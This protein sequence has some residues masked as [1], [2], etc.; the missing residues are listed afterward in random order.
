M[1]PEMQ[2]STYTV[3]FPETRIILMTDSI[4]RSGPE[5][6]DAKSQVPT[7]AAVIG[8]RQRK[9]ATT[10]PPNISS[11][12]KTVTKTVPSTADSKIVQ[13]H[14]IQMSPEENL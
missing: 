11:L 10:C 1:F 7:K 13:C 9:M 5:C 14:V 4:T 12:T 3:N 6:K 2:S 8:T